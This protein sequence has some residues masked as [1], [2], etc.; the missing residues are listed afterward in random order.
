[1][2][3]KLIGLMLLLAT[4]F[5]FSAIVYAERISPPIIGPQTAAL[6]NITP[7]SE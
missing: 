7:C 3:K 5:S 4:V 1:M 2:I 6:Y